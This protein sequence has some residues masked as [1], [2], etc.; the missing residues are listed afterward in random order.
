MMVAI[1]HLSVRTWATP[2]SLQKQMTQ[3]RAEYP[4]LLSVAWAG[5]IGVEIF[6]VISGFVIAYSAQSATAAGFARSRFLRLFPALWI[7]ALIGFAALAV[8]PPESWHSLLHRLADSLVLWPFPPYVAGGTW[9]LGIEVIFYATVF[10]TI[11]T[12]NIKRIELLAYA[13]GGLSAAYLISISLVDPGFVY[14]HIDSRIV[15]LSLF[16]HGVFF[17]IGMLIFVM[18]GGGMSTGRLA[19]VAFLLVGAICQIH[20]V[21][22]LAQSEFDG[23]YPD[24]LPVAVFLTAVGLIAL[25]LLWQPNIFVTR[26]LRGIGLMTYPLYLLNETFGAATLRFALDE[27]LN[28]YAALW[29]ALA[30]CLVLSFLVTIALE[31]FA[32]RATARAMDRMATTAVVDPNRLA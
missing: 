6:F 10:A 25:S 8:Y 1:F 15:N 23:A 17:A 26:T 21:D 5:F 28:R 4:E 9:T 12:G 29:A 11:A 16:N 24:T 27:G 18:S 14:A 13:L 19:F 30:A 3:G 31:P 20:F 32:R 7:C 22:K 2:N